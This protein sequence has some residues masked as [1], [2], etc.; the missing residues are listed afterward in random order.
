M[1]EWEFERAGE[2]KLIKVV[3]T[4]ATFDREGLIAAVL[5]GA[6]LMKLGCFDPGLVASG[7]LRKV[8]TDWSCPGGFPIYALYRKTARM[9][10]KLAAFL[11]FVAE[12]FAAFDPEEITLLHDNS[13]ADS[14][15]RRRDQARG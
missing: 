3:P 14:L 12:A 2:R 1:D 11:A 4:V 8:L 5:A 15:R 6:G 10:P 13:L 7:Q 9:P